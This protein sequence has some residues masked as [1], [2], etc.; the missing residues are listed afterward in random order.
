MSS[1]RKSVSGS[2]VRVVKRKL[3]SPPT[4]CRDQLAIAHQESPPPPQPSQVPEPSFTSPIKPIKRRLS[5]VGG[6]A[7]RVKTPSKSTCDQLQE[8]EEA[9]VEA[10]NRLK[11][12]KE[13]TKALDNCNSVFRFCCDTNKNDG[14]EASDDYSRDSLDSSSTRHTIDRRSSTS[15]HDSGSSLSSSEEVTDRP[16]CSKD[17]SIGKAIGKGK[18]GNVYLAKVKKT[19]STVALKV[20]F[21]APMRAANCVHSLRREVEIQCRL[22]HKNITQLFGYFHDTKNVY[23]ILEYLQQGELFKYVDKQGGCVSESTCKLFMQD[24]VAA[25]SYLHAHNIAHRGKEVTF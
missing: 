11:Q 13:N 6:P 12:D 2:A 7:V 22:K 20:L 10:M 16:W 21:K 4:V 25:I 1:R 18:F 24:I 3:S 23:L 9:A 15:S 14:G 17:F 19:R 8:E 5:T